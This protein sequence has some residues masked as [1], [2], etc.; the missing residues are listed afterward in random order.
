MT[1]RD[2]INRAR[3][4]ATQNGGLLFRNSVGQAWQGKIV[5]QSPGRIVLTNYRRVIYGL[6]KGSADLIGLQPVIVTPEMIGDELAVFWAVEIKTKND[7][8]KPEQKR[9]LQ[10]MKRRGAIVQI[11]R[12]SG[13]DDL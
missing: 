2:L 3:L 1:E 5:S 6:H 11:M 10:E 4:H 7:R 8:L 9:W 12:E 13:F